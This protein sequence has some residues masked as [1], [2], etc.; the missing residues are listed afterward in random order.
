M[1]HDLSRQHFRKEIREKRRVLSAQ[2]Q[3]QTSYDL[4]TQCQQLPEIS[5][6]QHFALYLSTDGELN[7]YPLIEWLWQHNKSVYV[8]VIHPF[9]KGQLLFLH[10]HQ[11]SELVVNRYDIIEPRLKKNDIIPAQELD[12]IF[13]PLVGFDRRGHRLGMGGGYYDRTLEPWFKTHKG[14]KPIGL[15]HDCQFVEELPIE[16]WDIPLPK[17][18]T[19]TKIWNWE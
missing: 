4:V 13:T 9:S 5:Q 2:I 19:P 18:V 11:K 3:H 8:P 1:K 12:V 7:T 17:I 6:G 15:A 16:S 14:A 10:Y